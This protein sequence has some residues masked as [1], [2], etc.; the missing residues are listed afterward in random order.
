M[1]LDMGEK[2]KRWIDG[3]VLRIPPW[4]ESFGKVKNSAGRRKKDI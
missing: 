3:S 1:A 2:V 4:L